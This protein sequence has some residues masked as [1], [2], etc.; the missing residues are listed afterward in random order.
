MARADAGIE[1]HEAWRAWRPPTRARAGRTS[2]PRSSASAAD[3]CSWQRGIIALVSSSTSP[4]RTGIR[5]DNV[6]TAAFLSRPQGEARRGERG[7]LPCLLPNV[8]LV[9]AARAH[10]AHLRSTRTR[11]AAAAASVSAGSR[12]EH[13]PRQGGTTAP[14]YVPGS[15][16]PP[17]RRPDVLVQ[18]A[19]SAPSGHG[20]AHAF[21]RGTTQPPRRSAYRLTTPVLV[22]SARFCARHGHHRRRLPLLSPACSRLADAVAVAAA[23]F[24]FASRSSCVAAL[25]IGPPNCY[26]GNYH[27]IVQLDPS[28]RGK[29]S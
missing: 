8:V 14:R 3:S 6:S 9:L 12:I 27:A 22:F 4:C 21:A 16:E 1:A 29:C 15:I 11:A 18:P 25:V 26:I 23:S 24:C 7:A 10:V 13:S 20:C 5:P 17:R 2:S 19:S 28:L